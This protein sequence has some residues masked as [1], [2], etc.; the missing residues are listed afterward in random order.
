MPN[1]QICLSKDAEIARLQAEMERIQD[2]YAAQVLRA[3][4]ADIRRVQA[5]AEIQSLRGQVEGVRQLLL[6]ARASSSWRMHT[7][8]VEEAIAL[9]SE[10]LA[11]LRGKDLA[12][13][14]P[15]DQPCHA[16]VLLE[17]ANQEPRE[18]P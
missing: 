12:C 15:L 13:W 5:H 9:L 7:E 14:C 1:C 4:A 2:R 6:E 11:A 16:D 3:K 10:P 18:T 8:K 17:L